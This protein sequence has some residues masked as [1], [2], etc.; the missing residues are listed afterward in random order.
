MI[1]KYPRQLV[2][3]KYTWPSSSLVKAKKLNAKKGKFCEAAGSGLAR[4]EKTNPH[5]TTHQIRANTTITWIYMHE[6]WEGQEE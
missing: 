1:A 6:E 5:C 2:S 4:Q 3:M